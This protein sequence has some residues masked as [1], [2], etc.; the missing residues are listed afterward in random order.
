M[1]WI[2]AHRG[3]SDHE[4]ENTLRAFRRAIELGADKVELDVR[5]SRD[6]HVVVIHDQDVSRTTDGSGDVARLT[7]EELRHFD[8]GKGE[9]IPTLHEVIDLV[10]C[11]CGLYIELKGAGTPA[12][13]IDVLRA[14][15]FEAETILGSFE[16]RLIVESKRLAQEIPT[17]L[18]VGSRVEDPVAE[19]LAAGAAYVHLCWERRSD[20]PA[21][22]LTPALLARIRA[23]G[24]GIILWHEERPDVINGLRGLPVD[25]V[26][27]NRPELLAVLKQNTQVARDADG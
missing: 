27:S 7:L 11:R 2:I 24:L 26:C 25:G 23:H 3:A 16:K 20:N 17:S 10:R 21:T 9:R 22:F 14:N 13:T 8:A 19:A 18:L 1:P 15:R 12:A 6:G 5:L 4:P